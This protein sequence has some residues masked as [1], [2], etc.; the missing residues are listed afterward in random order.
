[1]IIRERDDAFVMIEQDHHATLSGQLY[2]YI[3]TYL[4]LD[5]ESTHLAMR[6]AI[7]LHDVGWK[8]FDLSPIWND[9]NELPYDFITYPNSIKTVLYQQGIDKVANIS[10]YAAL[11]CSEHYVRFLENDTHPLSQQFVTME[12]KRQQ[13][14]IDYL[15]AFNQEAFLTHYEI[16]RFFDNLSLYI[17]LHEANAT[18]D[19]EIHYFL[20]K[21]IALPTL[22]GEGYLQL[23][24]KD[25][26]ILLDCTLFQD[27]ITIKLQQK[28]VAK[29]LIKKEGLQKAWDNTDVEIV[30]ITI[31]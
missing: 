14:I 24:W 26:A 20:K 4:S 22:Y 6:E 9:E 25:H 2:D 29:S 19:D 10:H 23:S 28:V 17:C 12:G 15:P 8:P 21:G 1:M 27:P 13:E 18:P 3:S 31:K 16:L 11:L 30:P 5:E 7:Y